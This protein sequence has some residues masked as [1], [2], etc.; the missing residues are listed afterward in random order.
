MAEGQW[1]RPRRRNRV[2]LSAAATEKLRFL[3]FFFVDGDSGVRQRSRS[4]DRTGVHTRRLGG[5]DDEDDALAPPDA[6]TLGPTPDLRC[7]VLLSK[8]EILFEVSVTCTD[9][10]LKDLGAAA[11]AQSMETAKEGV[12][13]LKR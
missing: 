8:P 1:C 6:P 11:A 10:P 4:S 7:F 3:F 13:S 9:P 5:D 2:F 12:N